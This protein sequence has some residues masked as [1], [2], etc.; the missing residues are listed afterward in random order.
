MDSTRPSGSR[1]IIYALPAVGVLIILVASI[2]FVNLMTARA[3]RRAVEVGVR[4]TAGASRRDLMWQFMGE[5]TLY[6]LFAML[7]AMT[8]VEL[9]LPAFNAFVDRDI[10]FDYWRDPFLL[11]ALVISVLMIGV[12]AGLYAALI[13]SL[14]SPAHV[15]KRLFPDAD[16]GGCDGSGDLSIHNTSAWYH[17]LRSSID[18]RGMPKTRAA[19]QW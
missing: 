7:L 13:L 1:P 19:P 11:T 18:K 14:F 2:N 6:T 9:L 8:L 3:T 17:Q 5:S 15:L 10:A 4:K 16:S 12:L